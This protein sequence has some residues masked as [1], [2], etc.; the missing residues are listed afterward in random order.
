M[1]RPELGTKCTC[2]GCSERFYD[3]N[4]APAICPKC[5]AQQQP[6]KA[7]AAA[8]PSRGV[9]GPRRPYRP[10]EPAIADEDA[11]MTAVED[12]DE[13]DDAVVDA[14]DDDVETV[15]DSDHDAKLD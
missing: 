10:P 3:L 1:G 6:Q 13:E 12:E 14:E 9:T 15:I 7:R 4:R 5:G 11:P 8:W 2:T